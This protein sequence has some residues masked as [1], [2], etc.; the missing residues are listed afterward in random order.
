MEDV[1]VRLKVVEEDNAVGNYDEEKLYLTEEQWLEKYKQ[2]EQEGNCLGGSSSGHG[3]GRSSK[4]KSRAAPDSGGDQ[5]GPLGTGGKD[6]CH[7]HGKV[8]HWARECL[9]RLK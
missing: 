9:S 6:K 3:K 4:S 8:G 1:M 7:I 5:F 2:K